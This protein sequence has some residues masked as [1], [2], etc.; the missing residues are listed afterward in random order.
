MLNVHVAAEVVEER[1]IGLNQR[2]TKDEEDSGQEFKF[3]FRLKV[4]VGFPF[5]LE[6]GLGTG[7]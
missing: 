7:R 3:K 4:H 6:W 5:L 2:A 1:V